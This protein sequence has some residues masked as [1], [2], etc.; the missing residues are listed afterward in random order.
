MILIWSCQEIETRICETQFPWDLPG[1]SPSEHYDPLVCLQ[2]P[3]G[4]PVPEFPSSAEEL[5]LMN[6]A[7]TCSSC[8][9][10]ILPSG[11]LSGAKEPWHHL[12][13]SCGAHVTV[14]STQ[15]SSY[16]G[17]LP[18]ASVHRSRELFMGA[19]VLVH[20]MLVYLLG[21]FDIFPLT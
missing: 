21:T 12:V 13:A 8:I 15:V 20:R 7:Y 16:P 11:R 10:G 4:Q 2:V 5:H 17:M 6:G 1:L 18:G 19:Q 14:V 9:P 3:C